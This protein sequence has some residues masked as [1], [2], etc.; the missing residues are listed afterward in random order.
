[1]KNLLQ[2]YFVRAMIKPKASAVHIIVQTPAAARGFWYEAERT[3]R[4][5]EQKFHIVPTDRPDGSYGSV[6]AGNKGAVRV[7]DSDRVCA[8]IRLSVDT[9]YA[10]DR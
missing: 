4:S 3:D 8:G 9:G 5:T 7:L 2:P 1:M 6:V 10:T